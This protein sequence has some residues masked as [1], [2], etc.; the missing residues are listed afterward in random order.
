MTVLVTLL[1]LLT[2]LTLT[3]P[4]TATS[5][6]LYHCTRPDVLGYPLMTRGPHGLRL[7]S[8]GLNRPRGRAVGAASCLGCIELNS[9]PQSS[10]PCFSG[11]QIRYHKV[12]C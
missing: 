4:T 7:A 10:Q 11:A 9:I 1:T 8:L 3:V 6:P 5:L 2:L 12:N